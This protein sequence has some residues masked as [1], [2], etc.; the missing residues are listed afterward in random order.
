MAKDNSDITFLRQ[1]IESKGWQL[2]R[3]YLQKNLD[4]LTDMALD[5]EDDSMRE[6]ISISRRDLFIKWR[7]YNK[8]LLDLPENLISSLQSGA[9]IENPAEFDPY[10]SEKDFQPK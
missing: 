2:L 6:V 5:D 8:L 10:F 3:K 9:P 7:R 4:W 1:L